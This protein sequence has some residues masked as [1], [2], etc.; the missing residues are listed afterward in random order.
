MALSHGKEH[1]KDHHQTK[2]SRGLQNVI[3]DKPL[4][5]R[6]V[7]GVTNDEAPKHVPIPTPE[8]ATLT[9][10]APTPMNLTAGSVSQEMVPFWK[11]LLAISEVGLPGY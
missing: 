11:L 3:G 1:E 10:T 9:M 8:P 5:Q 7:L 2:D 4:L 6:R